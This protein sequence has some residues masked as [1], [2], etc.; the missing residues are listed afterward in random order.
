[1]ADELLGSLAHELQGCMGDLEILK[2]RFEGQSA[3][4]NQKGTG[5]SQLFQIAVEEV[6]NLVESLESLKW[7]ASSLEALNQEKESEIFMLHRNISILYDACSS[8]VAELKILKAQI[9]DVDSQSSGRHAT[10]ATSSMQ[11]ASENPETLHLT[12]QLDFIFTDKFSMETAEKLLLSVKEFVSAMTEK[13]K[14]DQKELSLSIL[15]LQHEAEAKEAEKFRV[16]GELQ[17]QIKGAKAVANSLSRERDIDKARICDLEKQIEKLQEECH[18]LAVTIEDFRS[19][20]ASVEE[21]Q[22]DIA[23]LNKALSTKNQE[24]EGLMQALDEAE[25]QMETLSSK[26]E[27]LEDN[28]Q[29]KQAALENLESSRGKAVA[30]LSSTV[31]RLEDLHQLSEGLL[32]EVENLQVQL[33]SRDAEISRLRQEVTRCTNDVLASQEN[34]KRKNIEIRE[35]Q[36]RLE[37]IISNVGVHD[38]LLEEKEVSRTHV[39]LGALEKRIAT[40]MSESEGFR[41]DSKSKDVMLQDTQNKMEHLLSK[42][43]LLEASL[44]EKQ[45]QVERLQGQRGSGL[46]GVAAGPEVSEIEE[47]GQISKRSIPSAPVAPHV[48]N[49]KKVSNDQLALNIDI[50]SGQSTSDLEDESKGHVFKS[51]TTSRLIPKTTRPIADRID[52]IWVSGGRVLM[53]RPTARLGLIVYWIVLHLWIVTMML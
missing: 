48:R 21:M 2:E 23:S 15:Q 3:A 32:A 26:V 41:L 17:S 49:T 11:S 27:E 10:V 39:L 43:D 4:F 31:S 7:N 22:Q 36:A 47:T 50:E 44:H 20:D 53:R 34:M 40:I 13:S 33:E 5:M 16:F 30:K 46:G 12:E 28:I 18:A 1:M 6:M 45:T 8:A 14:Y 42:V 35:L 52:G 51:L 19:R 9:P 29:Q 38:K 24:L 25:L 37:T